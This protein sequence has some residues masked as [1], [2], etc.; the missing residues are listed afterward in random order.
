VSVDGSTSSD[1]DGLI[2]AYA[3]KFGDGATA[4]G[5]TAQHVYAAAG[6]YT[7][8]L[9]VTDDKGSTGAVSTITTVTAPPNS[10]PTAAFTTSVSGLKVTVDGSASSDSDGTVASYAW[11]FGDGATATGPNAQHGY[12]VA[13]NYS[14]TLT[15]TDN[16][17][18]SGTVTKPVVVTTAT[19]YAADNFARTVVNGL[20]TAQT[21]G[22]WSVVGNPAL[23]AS[24][25]NLGR[26]KMSAAG[27]GPA[28]YLNTVSARDLNGTVDIATDSVPT[29]G[30]TYLSLAVRR[31]G[32]S[33][34]RVRVRIQTTTTTL[35]LMKIVNGTES[36]LKAVT[37]PGLIYSAGDVLRLRIQASGS[38]T[39]TLTGKVWKVSGTEPAAWQISTTDTE[40]AL[41]NAGGV[42]MQGYLSASSTTIPVT[43]TFDN[44]AIGSIPTP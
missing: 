16:Q 33:D 17:G 15:V 39:T 10:A 18:V 22:A 32:S 6:S 30:G 36:V 14:V 23:F 44:L 1:P 7:V 4:A 35:Q 40:A 34:Y 20:G 25:G 3:W 38:G 8:T 31:Q 9:T 11:D 43:A 2:S 13:G 24:D 41:Q 28:A 42:G 29:G 5:S 12:G 19:V 37:V 21:G 27:A 26:I